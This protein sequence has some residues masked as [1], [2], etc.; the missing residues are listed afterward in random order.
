MT[1]GLVW[2]VMSG[3][4]ILSLLFLGLIIWLNAIFTPQSQLLGP[5][6]YKFDTLEKKV[7]LTFDDGPHEVFTPGIL[8]TLKTYG[9]KATFFV[10][11]ERAARY[12]RLLERMVAEGHEIGNHTYSHN[13]SL[14]VPFYPRA[15]FEKEIAAVDQVLTSH[16]IPYAPW[17]RFPMGFKC[18]RMMKAAR[19]LGK[20][21]VAFSFRSCDNWSSV[22]SLVERVMRKTYPG[23]IVVL[24]DG[25][26]KRSGDSNHTVEALPQILAGW[27]EKGYRIVTLG[28]LN[29]SAETGSA[30]GGI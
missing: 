7:A 13:H 12:P 27:K 17:L 22:D 18:G 30:P 28:E 15:V 6:L 26:H 23:A 24:H 14:S 5:V 25:P 19:R 20:R 4:I 16:R 3:Y 21:V 11:G 9:A 29:G 10:T 2:L 1:Y 8:D